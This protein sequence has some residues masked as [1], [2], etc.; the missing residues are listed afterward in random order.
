MENTTQSS[1]VKTKNITFGLVVG[2][3]FG[4]LAMMSGFAMLFSNPIPGILFIVSALI[5]L[6]PVSQYMK[7]K[8]HFS[9]SKGLKVLI[10]LILLGIAGSQMGNKAKSPEAVKTTSDNAPVQQVATAKVTAI[11]LAEDYKANEIAADAKYKGK[12]LEI[13]GIVGSIG[14]DILS[15]PYITFQTEQ[16]AIINQ[17][18]CMFAKTDE[19]V[20]A[21]LS[22]G[23]SVTVTGEVSGSVGNIIVNGCK[24]I[25]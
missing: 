5:A 22:K 7:E 25:K 24:V 11:Q 18:Q 14:K 12:L 20:L 23:Q 4:V 1:E 6:P 15:T 2:W 17:V 9:L 21:N 8:M 13:S 3:I 16:Y 10:I 19:Q